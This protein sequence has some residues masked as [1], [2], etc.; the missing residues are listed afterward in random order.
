MKIP[1]WLRP[2]LKSQRR[3]VQDIIEESKAYFAQ[4]MLSPL[5]S[6]GKTLLFGVS[7]ALF[8]GLGLVLCLVG[9]LRALQTETGGAFAGTWTFVPYIADAFV[10]ILFASAAVFVGLRRYRKRVENS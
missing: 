5:K 1:K 4:E 7:G 3:E 2:E 10:G 6:L 8:A 9:L